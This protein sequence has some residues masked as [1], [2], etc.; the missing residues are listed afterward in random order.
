MPDIGQNL[1]DWLQAISWIAAS[2]GVVVAFLKFMTEI[3]AGRIQRENDLRW[4]QASAGKELNDEMLK[5][6]EAIAAMQMLDYT[7]RA[8]D[9]PG[10]R[11]VSIT[12]DDLRFA[13]DPNNEVK[14]PHHIYIRDC[15]DRLFY[16]MTMLDHYILQTLVRPDDV[17][18]PLEY[19]IPRLANF[20]R[21]IELY[22]NHF[23]LSR[24]QKYLSRYPTWSTPEAADSTSH[25]SGRTKR[26]PIH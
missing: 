4:K 10:H 16:Y 15:F 6:P 14:K 2:I 25:R 18:Y 7:S 24:T 23:K 9:I 21:E 22:L 12:H 20:K 13:L 3:R 19:Y 26:S 5:H 17:S 8:Y 11:P 1:K